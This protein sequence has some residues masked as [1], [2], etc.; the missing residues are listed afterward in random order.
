MKIKSG[1]NLLE[2]TVIFGITSGLLSLVG[3]IAIYVTINSQQNIQKAKEYIW[4]L[5]AL[6]KDK[7]A[8]KGSFERLEWI[9]THYGDLH[10]SDAPIKIVVA[11]AVIVIAYC[12]TVWLVYILQ[13]INSINNLLFYITA[14]G[15]LILILFILILI[16]LTNTS[17]IGNLPT[18][19]KLLRLDSKTEGIRMTSILMRHAKLEVVHFPKAESIMLAISFPGPV[20]IEGV[21]F[22]IK[23][24]YEAL[25][26]QRKS[27]NDFNEKSELT[28]KVFESFFTKNYLVYEL[29]ERYLKLN[30]FKNYGE[31]LVTLEI[32]K[33]KSLVPSKEEEILELYYI[34]NNFSY[35]EGYVT[36]VTFPEW[37]GSEDL[38]SIQ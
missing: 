34:I 16:S 35:E 15:V 32:K 21:V 8:D 30:E 18:A 9:L 19:N 24:Y 26:N 3:L 28:Y 29:K 14:G 10:K 31:M 1:G 4:E 13:S 38:H 22:E 6:N 5:K 33:M 11:L 20:S 36:A 2:S 37:I 23:V 17:F 27:D 12:G 7:L 25:G